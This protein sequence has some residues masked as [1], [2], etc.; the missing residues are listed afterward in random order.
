MV[1]FEPASNHTA[2]KSWKYRF[3]QENYPADAIEQTQW[4][5]LDYECEKVLQ[6]L[7]M[8]VDT[9]GVA[10]SVDLEG[11]GGTVLKT[12][13]VNTTD[14]DRTHVETLYDAD[15]EL[16]AYKVR[17]VPTPGS[18]GKFQLFSHKF[19]RTLE[20]CP[21]VEWDSYEQF[22][23]SVGWRWLKQ[24][25]IMYKCAGQIK[26]YVYDARG[27][28]LHTETLPSHSTRSVERFYLPAVNGSVLN[29]SR[30]HRLVIQAVDSSK[31]FYLYR[32]NSRIEVKEVSGDQR[33]GFRQIYLHEHLGIQK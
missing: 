19:N 10:A 11:D 32:D 27:G 33:A 25:W 17:L 1:R 24:C 15:N 22:F 23:G 7:I 6:S 13:S 5:S 2:M 31:P 29:K 18:G 14:S 3:Q 20:P 28:L 12:F 8:E 4:E 26:V 9:G 16:I 21:L 30:G